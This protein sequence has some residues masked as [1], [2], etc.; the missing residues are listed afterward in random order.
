MVQPLWRTVWSS[1][2]K[3]KIELPYDPAIPLLGIN[4]KK[5]NKVLFQEDRWSTVCNA[6]LWND[7]FIW[8]CPEGDGKN[9]IFLL[10]AAFQLR[11]HFIMILYY[12]FSVH[13]IQNGLKQFLKIVHDQS[14]TKQGEFTTALSGTMFLLYLF[15]YYHIH[16]MLPTG[17][18][19]TL[20]F[21][22][23]IVKIILQNMLLYQVCHSP[24]C[25]L[26]SW[27]FVQKIMNALI[28]QPIK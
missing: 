2:K 10:T 14:F 11:K 6:T 27:C 1:L 25:G 9:F 20:N 5:N 15:C 13:N 26:P 12:F 3:L 4:P 18:W 24:S 28:L 21:G 7:Q 16:F 22:W 19:C 8:K 23:H 17:N